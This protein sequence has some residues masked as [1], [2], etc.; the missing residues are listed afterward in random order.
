MYNIVQ[1]NYIFP[2][3]KSLYLMLDMSNTLKKYKSIFNRM[4]LN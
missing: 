3:I 4:N 2:K 1:L